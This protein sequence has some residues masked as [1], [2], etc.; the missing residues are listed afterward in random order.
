MTSHLSARARLTLVYT[1]LFTLG[2][3]ALI[4]I[5]YLLVAHTLNNTTT[6]TPNDV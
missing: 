6:T 3:A 2:G 1:T 4:S 5:T